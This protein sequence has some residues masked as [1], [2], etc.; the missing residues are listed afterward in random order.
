MAQRTVITERQRRI[1]AELRQLREAAGVSVAEAGTASGSDGPRLSHIEAGRLR[2]TPERIR[3]IA[4]HCG[5]TDVTYI[6]ALVE[7]T[8]RSGEGWWSD[9]KKRVPKSLTDLAETE[10]GA[11][12][13]LDYETLY[14]PGLLQTPDYVRAVHPL[15]GR[16]EQDI[17]TL[18]E[19]RLKRQEFITGKDAPQLDF[20]IHEAALHMRFAGIKGMRSQLLHIL[21]MAE[22]PNITIRFFPFTVEEQ[23][24]FGSA[25]YIMQP[26][27][28]RLS[29]VLIDHPGKAEFLS[30]PSSVARYEH[31]YEELSRLAL[32]PIDTDHSPRVHSD[33]DS[34]G[35]IQHILYQL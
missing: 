14:I 31:T 29:S 9:Y 12:S 6:D 28:R 25:L 16:Q 18:I 26:T 1:G 7:M 34:W 21:K 19:F 32:P 35:L 23:P 10:A 5:C 27:V 24:P 13:I 4:K 11:A 15:R 8:E 17:E 33:R 30:D 2:A 22:E 3:A 20:V